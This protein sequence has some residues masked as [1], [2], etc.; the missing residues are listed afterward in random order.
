MQLAIPFQANG[1]LNNKADEFIIDYDSNKNQYQNLVNFI[2]A[3]PN[4]V[5]NINIKSEIN[6]KELE[7]LNKIG[8]I[9]IILNPKK[10][11]LSAQ[12]VEKG[13]DFYFK[14]ELIPCNFYQLHS[15]LSLGVSD[16]YIQDD[17]C[18]EMDNV[19]SYCRQYGVNLRVVLNTVPHSMLINQEEKNIVFYRPE[20]T[21]FDWYF[22]IAEF[23]VTTQDN[24]I[25]WNLLNVLYDTYFINKRW[26]GNLQE[27]IKGLPFEVYNKSLIPDFNE[28]KLNCKMKCRNRHSICNKCNQFL[29]ISNL[30]VAK[31]IRFDFS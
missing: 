8:K 18:Y 10:W 11:A 28:C 30:L 29:D 7:A 22:D 4:K 2:T 9:K 5:I 1:K 27:I 26:Y 16:I 6:F 24:K 21:Y 13:I 23:D 14:K 15:I 19:K 25:N 20:D 17:L 3:F 12:F 31:D